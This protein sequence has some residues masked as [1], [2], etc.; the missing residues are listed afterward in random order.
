MSTSFKLNTLK[1]RLAEQLIQD[2]F[3]NNGYNVFN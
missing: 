3:V 1:G 2:L